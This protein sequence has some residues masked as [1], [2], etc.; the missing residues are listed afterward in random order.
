[1]RAAASLGGG[2]T[3]RGR[4]RWAAWRGRRWRG[5]GRPCRGGA[6]RDEAEQEASMVCD[7][8]REAREAES[9][10][11]T[12][13]WRF[14]ASWATGSTRGQEVKKMRSWRPGQRELQSRGREVAGGPRGR[15]RATS[16]RGRGAA[17]GRTRRRSSTCRR[18][19]AYTPRTTNSSCTTSA[20]R[21]RPAAAVPMICL[22]R[23]LPLPCFSRPC[24][25]SPASSLIAFV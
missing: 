12:R 15:R 4:A 5:S 19:S 25:P 23:L 20:G 21:W 14:T 6:E 9:T 8:G 3:S 10:G 13:S 1:M 16:R 7:V 24:F 2:G 17:G 11:E 22:V 18:A